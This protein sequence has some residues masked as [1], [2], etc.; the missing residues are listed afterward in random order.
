MLNKSRNAFDWV[1]KATANDRI[2]SGDGWERSD[3]PNMSNWFGFYR[4]DLNNDGICDWYLNAL[5]PIATGGDRDT[6]NT[7]YIGGPSRWARIGADIPW[8]N[9]MR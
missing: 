9:Q 1:H 7:L 3:S 5:T 2:V 6:I 4:V 8:T